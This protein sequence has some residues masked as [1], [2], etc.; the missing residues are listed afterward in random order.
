M[1]KITTILFDCDNTLVL[2][3]E[4]A[5][6]ACADLINEICEKQGVEKRFTGESLILEFVGQNFRGML[7]SLQARYGIKLTP[8][9]L[10]D[11]VKAEE[12]AV[13]AKIRAHGQPCVGVM[14]QLEKLAAEKKYHLAVVSSSAKRRVVASIEK[15]GQDK[16]FKNEEVF[17]AATSLPVPTSKPDPAIYL[18]AAK[19]LGKD[20]SECLAIED[21]KSGTTSGHR[22]GILVLGYTGPY[23]PERKAE[24]TQVLK[25]AGAVVV[26]DDWSEF[27]EALAKIEAL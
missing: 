24:M 15:V 22:A 6:A 20:V 10:E 21:S 4:L 1:P 23:P 13:I 18:H 8:E 7:G 5:F 26:M 16:F 12:D 9:E 27:P 14:E 25:D 3:E 2:S 17:S 19:V 11:Y